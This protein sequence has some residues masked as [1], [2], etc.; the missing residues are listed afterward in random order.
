M[1]LFF[2][3]FGK[4]PKKGVDRAWSNS[5]NRLL[6]LVEPLTRI[7]DLAEGAKTEGTLVDP[8]ILKPVVA[9]DGLVTSVPSNAVACA[10]TD[11]SDPEG[12]GSGANPLQLPGSDEKRQKRHAFHPFKQ[13]I[14]RASGEGGER[15]AGEMSGVD[16][17]P[18][19]QQQNERETNGVEV[20]EG[21]GPEKSQVLSAAREAH[22][23][24]PSHA[25]GEAW[26]LQLRPLCGV[27][28]DKGCWDE[29]A[30]Q[31]VGKT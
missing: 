18:E 20:R 1:L 12:D 15:G 10:D 19:E 13:W 7:V 21:S 11:T 5:Q 3:K 4:D 26:P 24:F 16:V 2:T 17:G 8:E 28:E 27:R 14:V 29:G 23:G 25:S 31:T 30:G 9:C 22:C 6:D